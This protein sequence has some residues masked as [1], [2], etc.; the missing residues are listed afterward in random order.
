MGRG[1]DA[2]DILTEIASY[3]TIGNAFFARLIHTEFGGWR[4]LTVVNSA[5]H[6]ARTEAIFRWVFGLAPDR[7]YELTFDT[8]PDVGMPPDD[9]AIR[10]EHES[11]RLRRV[12]ELRDQIGSMAELYRFL[13]HDHDCYSTPGLLKHRER[14]E[15][16]ERVY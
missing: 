1:L 4:R 13:Y 7:G 2:K 12:R 9:L 5:F 11:R 6:M 14:D 10:Y 3:D 16:L 15:R 8:V